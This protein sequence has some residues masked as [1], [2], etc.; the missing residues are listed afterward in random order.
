[1]RHKSLNFWQP[2]LSEHSLEE[3]IGQFAFSF[4]E[5]IAWDFCRIPS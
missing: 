5:H 2:D 3:D 4:S 1:M